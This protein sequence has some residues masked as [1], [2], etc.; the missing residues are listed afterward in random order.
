METNEP[1]KLEQI[2]G[3]FEDALARQAGVADPIVYLHRTLTLVPSV[4]AATITQASNAFA[5]L[6]GK[7]GFSWTA[8]IY[9]SMLIAASP[10]REHYVVTSQ[11]EQPP[12]FLGL[13]LDL[14]KKLRVSGN[15]GCSAGNHSKGHMH[16][17]GDAGPFAGWYNRG[18]MEIDGSV[19]ISAGE[20]NHGHMKIRGN[21]GA[22]LGTQNYG[23]IELEGKAQEPYGIGKHGRIMIK[24]S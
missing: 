4:D 2:V 7:A 8:G 18:T 6:S 16:V 12:D 19:G 14:R 24:D 9:L 22:E 5:R 3:Q 23:V 10:D 21:A 13:E 20:F 15:V 1:S 11:Y 17:E